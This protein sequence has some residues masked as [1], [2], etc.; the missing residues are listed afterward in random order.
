MN[1]LRR[2]SNIYGQPRP[3]GS[4]FQSCRN[5]LPLQ[6]HVYFPLSFL[7][8]GASSNKV[9]KHDITHTAVGRVGPRPRT[10]SPSQPVLV[11]SAVLTRP[12]RA[13]PRRLGDS[14]GR[15]K[16]RHRQR[17]A[18][19]ALRR[20]RWG[21]RTA[22]HLTRLDAMRYRSYSAGESGKRTKACQYAATSTYSPNIICGR[23]CC[24]S[25]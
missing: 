16:P 18:N 1:Q 5:Q 12:C 7:P 6:D 9:G 13:Y 10:P 3:L 22:P 8:A 23:I 4:S 17:E 11:R 24:Q 19:G 25:A 15:K 20:L 2:K 21:T 14:V